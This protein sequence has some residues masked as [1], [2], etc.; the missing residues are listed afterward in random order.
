MSIFKVVVD[1]VFPE[2]GQRI[3]GVEVGQVI[4]FESEDCLTAKVISMPA[5]TFENDSVVELDRL[6]NQYGLPVETGMS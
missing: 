1:S 6:I 5:T 4:V 2:A 3:L